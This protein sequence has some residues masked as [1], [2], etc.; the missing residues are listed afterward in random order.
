MNQH[1]FLYQVVSEVQTGELTLGFEINCCKICEYI[2]PITHTGLISSMKSN[3]RIMQITKRLIKKEPLRR[4]I[5][6]ACVCL[7]FP[8]APSLV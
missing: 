5:M 8:S 4:P 2:Y 3:Q 7:F 1:P 6:C